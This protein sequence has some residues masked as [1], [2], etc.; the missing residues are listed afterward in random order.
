MGPGFT[1]KCNES[2]AKQGHQTRVRGGGGR[3]RTAMLDAPEAASQG[4]VRVAPYVQ[5]IDGV[6]TSGGPGA[7]PREPQLRHRGVRGRATRVQ[8]WVLGV[9]DGDCTRK[10]VREVDVWVWVVGEGGGGAT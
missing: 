5:L 8:G 2:R 3:H 10:P 9:E 6:G 4:H 7:G 1:L